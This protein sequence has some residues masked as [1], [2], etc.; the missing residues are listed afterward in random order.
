[1]TTPVIVFRTAD[2]SHAPALFALIEANLEEGHLLPRTLG[3]LVVRAER[4]TIALRGQAKN[5]WL[6]QLPGPGGEWTKVRDFPAP[7]AR[8]FHERWKELES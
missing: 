4:F 1:M 3:E 6:S 8:T 5:G 7:A 2:P